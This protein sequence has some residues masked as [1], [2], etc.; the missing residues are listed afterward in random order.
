MTIRW[1]Q[2]LARLVRADAHGLL[3]TLEDRSLLLKQHL[4]EAELELQHRRARLA[5]LGEEE[6][7]LADDGRRLGEAVERLDADVRLALAREREDLARFAI[8][9]LL[10]LQ[11]ERRACDERAEE[12]RSER[13]ELARGLA[14]Q[15]AELA[16]LRGRVDRQLAAE[17]RARPAT[18]GGP[19]RAPAEEDVEMELLRRR[20]AAGGAS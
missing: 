6:Q 15:E 16:A 17:A 5:A 8:R 3:E 9:R 10:P 19:G 18:G 13:A 2:R 11:G 12:L 4:R 7:R 14:E 1:T 20:Q